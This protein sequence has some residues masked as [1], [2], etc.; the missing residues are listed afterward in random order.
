[1]GLLRENLQHVVSGRAAAEVRL[2]SRRRDDLRAGNELLVR[3]L[4]RRSHTPI[5]HA[6]H[7]RRSHNSITRAD[8]VVQAP[9]PWGALEL[10]RVQNRMR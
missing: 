7:T 10:G 5:T 2:A 8:A 3:L 6:D 1:M 9:P 4:R